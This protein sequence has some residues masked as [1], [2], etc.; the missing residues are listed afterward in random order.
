[1][2]IF[3]CTSKH[4]YERIPK[5][6]E[7]LEKSGHVI[8]LP[9][10][11]DNPMREEEMKIIGK[12]EHINWKGNMIK[13]QK[14]KIEKNDAILVINME[15]N[16]IENYIGGAT[17]LEMF[18]AWELNKKIFLFN[19]IPSNILKDEITAFNPIIINGDLKKIK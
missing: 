5:I 9:N 7:E 2:K 18:K 13:L 14:E 6:K 1:M 15:K 10:S 11:Y 17:F 12:L 4:L 19:E 16:E 3:I 8:C